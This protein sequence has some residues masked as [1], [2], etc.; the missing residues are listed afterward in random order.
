MARRVFRSV[1]IASSAAS[2]DPNYQGLPTDDVPVAL[3]DRLPT[4]TPGLVVAQAGSTVVSEGGCR[5][6]LHGA[7][8]DATDATSH[9]PQGR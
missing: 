4:A 5:G 2:P 9:M 8:G 3:D 7:T 1:A 6:L